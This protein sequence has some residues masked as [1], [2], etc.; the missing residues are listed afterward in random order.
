MPPAAARLPPLKRTGSI[1]DEELAEVALSLP[2]IVAF[3][4]KMGA[5][6]TTAARCMIDL[7]GE[8]F[9]TKLS[10]ASPI[11]KMGIMFGFPHDSMYGT[12]AQKA[13]VVPQLGMSG[14]E[15]MQKWG[16]EG[17]REHFPAVLPNYRLLDT[18]GVFATILY[19]EIVKLSQQPNPPKI[20]VID[21]LRFKDEAS[22]LKLLG[23]QI[24]FITSDMQGE[25]PDAAASHSSESYFQ[26]IKEEFATHFLKNPG[27]NLEL[28]SRRIKSLGLGK[29]SI[30][31]SLSDSLVKVR[32]SERLRKPS[33]HGDLAI[34]TPWLSDVNRGALDQLSASWSG[35]KFDFTT[36][37]VELKN[38]N[39]ALRNSI[40]FISAFFA[41]GDPK[42]AKYC[43]GVSKEIGH[44]YEIARY[45]GQQVQ[46]ENEHARAY[47]KSLEVWPERAQARAKAIVKPDSDFYP[48]RRKIEFLKDIAGNDVPLEQ[49]LFLDVLLEATFACEFNPI[50]HLAYRG[51]FKTFTDANIQIARDEALHAKINACIYNLIENRLSQKTANKLVQRIVDVQLMFAKVVYIGVDF[52]A[53]WDPA[54][55]SDDILEAG[56][57]AYPGLS[58]QQMH[59]YVL[60]IMNIYMKKMNY[61]I[62]YPEVG[63]ECPCTHMKLSTAVNQSNGFERS[64]VDY[65]GDD[66]DIPD[67]LA[68]ELAFQGVWAL[69]HRPNRVNEDL[70]EETRRAKINF[71]ELYSA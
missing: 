53:P 56:S 3:S 65:R 60:Y 68:L 4:G 21:D 26:L 46:V 63:L 43:A 1:S 17:I 40:Y 62:P 70:T 48:I 71:A 24:T 35:D 59:D 50:Y 5:G 34:L 20:I 27:N 15:F 9:V 16:T 54:S 7:Y 38:T 33:P 23:A 36:H 69:D 31:T 52:F 12:P 58:W 49:R 25:R 22:M 66:A 42:I 55:V 45:F 10:F 6:K 32:K 64:G 57:E 13:Q 51:L 11:K 39:P 47:T 37:G 14:R 2:Q 18:G 30:S 44:W 29:G 61:E 41:E 67:E 8:E 28:L 19:H